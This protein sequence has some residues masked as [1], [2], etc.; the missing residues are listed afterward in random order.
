MYQMEAVNGD[1]DPMYSPRGIVHGL[2]QAQEIDT[3][4]GKHVD[5][6]P[7]YYPSEKHEDFSKV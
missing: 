4:N 3:F 5:I 1:A 6:E 2:W 7:F